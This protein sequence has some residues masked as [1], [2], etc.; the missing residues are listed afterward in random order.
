MVG[1]VQSDCSTAVLSDLQCDPAE[2][3]PLHYPIGED[4]AAAMD[5]IFADA[6][7]VKTHPFM[8]RREIIAVRSLP[9]LPPSP[10]SP[11]ACTV[12]WG[13]PEYYPI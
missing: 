6:R 5:T 9:T 1:A 8:G 11:R 13:T 7:L 3:K 2:I 10:P 4:L 12:V